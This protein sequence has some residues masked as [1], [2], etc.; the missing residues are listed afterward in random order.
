[1]QLH[2]AAKWFVGIIDTSNF[3]LTEDLFDWRIN[4]LYVLDRNKSFFCFVLRRQLS[5]L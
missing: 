1:M 4:D 2:I 3:G 5:S